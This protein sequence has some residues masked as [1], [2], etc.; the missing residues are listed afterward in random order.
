VVPLLSGIPSALRTA[1]LVAGGVAIG[2]GVAF[3]ASALGDD[4]SPPAALGRPAL[5]EGSAPLLDP[6]R[7]AEVEGPRTRA[8][9]PA[10][11]VE[12][13][14]AAEQEGDHETSFGYLADA[15]RVEY[16]SPAAWAADHPDALPPVTGFTV[17]PAPERSTTVTTLTQ[18]RSSLDAVTG[19]V[20]ARARTSWVTVQEEGGWAVDVLATTQ[21]ALLPPD[22]EATAAVQDWAERVQS[23]DITEADLRELRGRADLAVSLCG[24]TDT[25]TA[26]SATPLSQ[27]DAAPLQTSFGAD[28]VSWARVV[29]VDG[30]VPLRAV[31]APVADAW[32]V[33]GVLA[34]A[35][36]AR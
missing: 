18:Y 35:G 6:A 31:V 25:L 30:P 36:S 22:A 27:A 11:A 1:A 21:Q 14:L 5:P 2:L 19:L 7:L 4:D 26:A 8:D 12:A 28:V 17:E 34:P 24:S 32:T 33:V 10:A 16:G 15:V 13:F 20:P 23:C 3:G 29:A 9:S